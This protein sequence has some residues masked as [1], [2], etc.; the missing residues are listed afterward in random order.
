MPMISVFRRLGRR[1]RHS[2]SFSVAHWVQDPIS[3]KTNKLVSYFQEKKTDKEKGV[4]QV[5]LETTSTHYQQ[6]RDPRKRH[7]WTKQGFFFL[8]WLMMTKP[9]KWPYLRNP[10]HSQGGDNHFPKQMSNDGPQLVNC[11]SPV[12]IPDTHKV[13]PHSIYWAPCLQNKQRHEQVFLL[14]IYN[15]DLQDQRLN[16]KKNRTF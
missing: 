10:A 7:Y 9:S 16:S 5:K 14:K 12:V 11:H 8:C 1:I 4:P 6:W 2:R 15:Q 3:K 13:K